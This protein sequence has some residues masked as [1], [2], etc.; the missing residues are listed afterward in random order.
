MPI[1]NR[2][3]ARVS[4]I[5][6]IIAILD[7]VFLYIKEGKKRIIVMLVLVRLKYNPF[8]KQITDKETLSLGVLTSYIEHMY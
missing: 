6:V 4:L 3:Q 5:L 7:M 2:I 1:V 8:H